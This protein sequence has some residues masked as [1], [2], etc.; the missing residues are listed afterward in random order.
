VGARALGLNAKLPY[1]TV[2]QLPAE[3]QTLSPAEVEDFLCIYKDYF[4]A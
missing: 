4:T 3:L 2:D 1:L